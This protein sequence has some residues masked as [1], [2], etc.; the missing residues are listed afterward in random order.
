MKK[1]NKL[2]KNSIIFIAIVI[3]IMGFSSSYSSLS[4]DNLAY[5]L[6][7]GIDT[8][9]DNTLEV[10]FQ[11][12]TPVSASEGG[13]S[14]KPTAI[15]N[16]VTASSLSNA[17]NL[18]NGYLGKQINMSHCKVIIFSEELATQGIS[19]E[20]YTLI[21]D[22]QIRPS[23]N[24]VISKCS[25]KYYLEQ[26]QPELE[27]LISKYY[28]IFANSSEYTG[29]M[30]CATIGSF[31][32]SLT[33]PTC[34]SYGIL[35]GVQIDTSNQ[36]TGET[37]SQKDYSLKANNSSISGKNGAENIG[38]AVFR[39]DKL[40]G[41]LDAIETIAFLNIRN[42]IERF[43]ISIPDPLNNGDYLD[44]YMS[45]VKTTEIKVDTSTPTPYISVKL[46]FDGRVYSMSENAKYLSPEILDKISNNCNSYL[47]STFKDYLYKTSKEFKSDINNFGTSSLKNFFTDKEFK[48]YNWHENYKNAFFDVEVDTSIKSGM[49]L[50]ET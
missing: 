29:Y 47:E 3:F 26:T 11:F 38:V 39:A 32:N 25:A 40:V 45:P 13:S 33:C 43:L 49:L 44:I 28:E 7:I 18:V 23:T 30:P 22:S 50:T 42:Q 9:S 27:T 20:I 15:I 17:I 1:M 36:Q 24:V 14:E 16:T 41:E 37:N 35:G 8:A 2:F 31:F 21:N 46:K 4:I 5:V 48:E 10:S 34:Q 6:A 19:D 12:S